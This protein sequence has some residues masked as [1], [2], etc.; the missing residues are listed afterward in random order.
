M[1]HNTG[2][3]SINLQ[4]LSYGDFLP[5]QYLFSDIIPVRV[6]S[7]GKIELLIFSKDEFSLE[8][9]SKLLD[10]AKSFDHLGTTNSTTLSFPDFNDLEHSSAIKKKLIKFG[11]YSYQINLFVKKHTEDFRNY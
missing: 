3:N 10:F 4:S 7:N 9:F 5:I 11:N 1:Y 6:E 8:N 2:L